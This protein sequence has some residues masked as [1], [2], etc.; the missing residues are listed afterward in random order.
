MQTTPVKR[1]SVKLIW[2]PID[3]MSA[4][5]R[6]PGSIPFVSSRKYLRPLIGADEFFN[7][8][9]SIV[10]LYRLG[11]TYNVFIEMS[12]WSSDWLVS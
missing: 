3:C 2:L 11:G 12:W 1:G 5:E 7:Y 8:I 9:C 10:C 6:L 4:G